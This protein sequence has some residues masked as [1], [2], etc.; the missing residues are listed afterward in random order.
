MSDE[1]EKLE[2]EDEQVTDRVDDGDFEGHQ[3]QDEQVADRVEDADFE[4]HQLQ[5]EAVDLG[6]VGSIEVGIVDDGSVEVG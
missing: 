5:V 2:I 6:S 3:L 4:G 1:R